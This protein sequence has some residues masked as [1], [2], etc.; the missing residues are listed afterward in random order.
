MT[1]NFDVNKLR[2]NL[3]TNSLLVIKQ[4][5]EYSN[6][7]S[8]K[9][10]DVLQRS[11]RQNRLLD[12]KHDLKKI[13]YKIKNDMTDSIYF[14][15]QEITK[16]I[17]QTTTSNELSEKIN[18]YMTNFSLLKNK[19]LK[20]LN[21]LEEEILYDMKKNERYEDIASIRRIFES[22]KESINFAIKSL[23]KKTHDLINE[24][25]NKFNIEH[26]SL[27]EDKDLLL[28]LSFFNITYDKE[29][30]T[31][32]IDD[33]GVITKL[34]K[35]DK[36]TY[37]IKDNID[38]VL[39]KDKMIT[40]VGIK[41][42]GDLKKAISINNKL[43]NMTFLTKKKNDELNGLEYNFDNGFIRTYENQTL[44]NSDMINLDK[45]DDKIQDTINNL[46]T[47]ILSFIR[48]LEKNRVNVNKN[49]LAFK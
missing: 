11:V 18:R 33:N 12:M 15:I 25:V 34:E 43:N 1:E 16:I 21:E 19:G 42:N 37:K 23:D 38:L 49:K 7:F 44:T 17:N 46:D 2:E 29:S 30:D 27:I 45:L 32:L 47:N 6:K 5:D 35:I 31:L 48:Q 10:M 4:M 22:Y 28:S 41:I 3:H 24:S 36:N 20:A 13:D 8:N 40:S 39:I 14:M 26:N 9:L